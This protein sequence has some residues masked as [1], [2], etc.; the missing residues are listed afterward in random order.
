MNTAVS[1]ENIY[2]QIP[3][4]SSVIH[5][6]QVQFDLFIFK[7]LAYTLTAYCYGSKSVTQ[8]DASSKRYL[9]DKIS[10]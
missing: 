5:L 7:R 6:Y 8:P 3:T 2:I 10:C 1:T 4:E 9:W